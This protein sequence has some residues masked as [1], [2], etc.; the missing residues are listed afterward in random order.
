MK[1]VIIISQ[2][3]GGL[4]DNLQFSTLPELYTKKGYDVYI[5]VNNKVRNPEIFDLVWFK[6]PF[7]KGIIDDK[8]GTVVGSNMQNRW[9]HPSK[10][11]Y[12]IHRIEIAH[13]FPKTNF[14]PKIY[15]T[16]IFNQQYNNDII[17]DLTGSSQVYKMEKYMEY[18][19]YFLPLIQNKN[20]KLVKIIVF[21]NIPII[22][23]FNE[24]YNY[25]KTKI[26]NIQ[27]LKINSLINYCD[28]I[29]SCDTIIIVNSGINSLASAIKQDESK[30]NIFCYNPWAHFTPEEIKGCFNYKNVEYFQ[31]KIH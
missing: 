4:G 19:N 27:Y 3:W 1:K 30:P 31:S 10:N 26:S 14:Y 8:F 29:K 24:V 6:N 12:S 15:Y 28:I 5:S 18:I 20:D 16:P 9:P 17:I 11:E 13:G 25:L 21:E 23:L 22:Q 7:V 2:P